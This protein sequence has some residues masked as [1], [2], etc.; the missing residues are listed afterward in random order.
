METYFTA[1]L[2]DTSLTLADFVAG[3]AFGL[4]IWG[5]VHMLRPTDKTDKPAE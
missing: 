3:V 2:V 4:G 5:L 1:V